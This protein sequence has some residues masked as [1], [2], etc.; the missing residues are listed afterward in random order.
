MIGA[1]MTTVGMPASASAAIGS[2]RFAG[3][4]AR[5]SIVRASLR[6]SV[7]TESATLTSRFSAMRAQDVDVA[8]RPAPIW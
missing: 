7:V 5:G 8:Q 4:A 1:T 2:S 3:V 6:S